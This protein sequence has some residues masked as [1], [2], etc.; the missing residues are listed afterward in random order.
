MTNLYRRQQCTLL[1]SPC[2]VTDIFVRFEQNLDFSRQIFTKV[3]NI[4]FHGDRAVGAALVYV[5]TDGRTFQRYHFLSVNSLPVVS[6]AKAMK[7]WT[8]N[9]VLTS[10][11]FYLPFGDPQQLPERCHVCYHRP[12]QPALKA[13]RHCADN[14]AVL[15]TCCLVA[16]ACHVL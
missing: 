4:K 2:K 1:R 13:G 10:K 16:G 9:S 14:V 7:A 11:L 12:P 8:A 5:R 6:L 3:S 15:P